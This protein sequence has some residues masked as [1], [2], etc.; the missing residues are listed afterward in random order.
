MSENKEREY[1]YITDGC[2]DARDIK[3]KCLDGIEVCPLC[4]G[5]GKRVQTYNNGCGMGFSRSTGPCDFCNV[6]GFVY[7]D[8]A[9]GVTLSV[10]NQIA[11]A[12]GVI[13][14]RYDAFGLD[15]QIDPTRGAV[16]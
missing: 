14:T 8:T 12:S 11:V 2:L 3:F 9:R 10:T 16:E 7:K 4:H 5:N 1:V 13:S 15:W 6:T